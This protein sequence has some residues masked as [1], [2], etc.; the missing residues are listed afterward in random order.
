VGLSEGLPA[1]DRRALLQSAILLV[2]GSIAGSPALALADTPKAAR[3]FSAAQ[4]ATMAE[5][6]DI[7][8]PKTD[9][10]G[11]KE[12]GVPEALDALMTNWASVER[13]QQFRRLI[14]EIDLAALGSGGTAFPAM[15]K[16]KRAELVRSYD[17]AKLAAG[18]PVY[19]KFKELVITLYYSSEAGA[20]KE[21]R[22]ELIP[23]KWEP[24]IEMAP[25]TRAW[26]F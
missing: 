18:D 13:Q 26:A 16:A 3:F 4:F 12:A 14:D 21:L 10:P 1:V 15:P 11:A 19:A 2:G 17:T 8:L 24:G 20:T 25:D 22:Y 6:A 5:V 9:T 23:G 7:I